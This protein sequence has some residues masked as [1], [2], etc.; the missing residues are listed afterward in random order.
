[1]YNILLPNEGREKSLSNIRTVCFDVPVVS[2]PFGTESLVPQ[3]PDGRARTIILLGF[4]PLSLHF[5]CF[6]LPLSPVL[7]VLLDPGKRRRAS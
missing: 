3:F 1:M 2:V 5:V 4:L 6:T 7:A